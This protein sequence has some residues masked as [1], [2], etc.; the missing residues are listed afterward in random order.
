MK[1]KWHHPE[2]PS[3]GRRYFRSIAELEGAP[4]SPEWYGQEFPEGVAE[5]DDAAL[6]LFETLL[7]LPDPDLQTAIVSGEGLEGATLGAYRALE[8]RIAATEPEWTIEL[9]PPIG[10]LP[11]NIGF[12]ENGP[13]PEGA[14]ALATVEWAAQRIDLPIVLIGPEAQAAQAAE[15]LASRGISV[16]VRNGAGPLRADWGGM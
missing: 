10:E 1:R 6:G 9:L 7:A 16:T 15:L 3:T 12:D 8:G 14:Q 5:M 11:Q 2:E 13:T 4:E